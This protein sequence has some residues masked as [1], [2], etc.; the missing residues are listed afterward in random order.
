MALVR[1]HLRTLC[2]LDQP[3]VRS[4]GDPQLGAGPMP[5]LALNARLT[6]SMKTLETVRAILAGGPEASGVVW[7]G[8]QVAAV[9]RPIGLGNN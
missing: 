4:L 3:E 6:P 9:V 7:D 2:A 5:L 1:P 8:N